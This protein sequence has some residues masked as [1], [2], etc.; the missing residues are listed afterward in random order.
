MAKPTIRITID[1]VTAALNSLI[2]TF[3]LTGVAAPNCEWLIKFADALPAA[4]TSLVT[5]T[6]TGQYLGL[7]LPTSMSKVILGTTFTFPTEPA[8][9]PVF[10]SPDWDDTGRQAELLNHRH[11]LTR[12]YNYITIDT[13]LQNFLLAIIPAEF[14]P[15]NFIRSGL[16]SPLWPNNYH[17][18]EL[19]D[20]IFTRWNHP[21]DEDG[22]H[23]ETLFRSTWNL[24]DTTLMKYLMLMD[25]AQVLAVILKNPYTDRQLVRQAH[26]VIKRTVDL[27]EANKAWN[28]LAFKDKTYA[29]LKEV[30]VNEY[31]A[32]LIGGQE[33]KA[34]TSVPREVHGA[35]AAPEV[36]LP[37]PAEAGDDDS[38]VTIVESSMTALSESLQQNFQLQLADMRAEFAANLQQHHAYAVAPQPPL[39]YV[40]QPPT[41]PAPS[42]MAIQ[43]PPYVVPSPAPPVPPPPPQHVVPPPAPA[44]P[45][46]P[47]ARNQAG[48]NSNNRTSRNNQQGTN[49]QRSRRNQ[50]NQNVPYSNNV[51]KF[52]NHLYCASCG[53]D[54][55]HSS[56]MCPN[57][58]AGHDDR[59]IHKEQAKAIREAD[60]NLKMPCLSGYHRNLWPS[61]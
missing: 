20:E 24:S 61:P 60:P 46:V 4:I 42:T 37:I 41:A 6:E 54:V 7:C 40:Y 18:F 23:Y 58:R 28:A 48:R 9:S 15:T 16:N 36:S 51:K 31:Q 57:K 3:R 39:P 35:Y 22:H 49:Q 44:A 38:L 26:G 45:P 1:Q 29:K 17:A 52:A 33:I 27:S 34:P 30:Y 2:P 19:I 43:S 55:D 53:C 11:I 25:R 50:N 47:S 56:P 5:A 12:Y 59:V 8:P 32:C 21:N 10:T 14:L 13:A